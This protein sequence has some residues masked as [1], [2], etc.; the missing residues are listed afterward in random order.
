MIW[1]SVSSST[2]APRLGQVREPNADL[3]VAVLPLA[4]EQR[5]ALS[6]AGAADEVLDVGHPLE[7]VE[8]LECPPAREIGERPSSHE[9]HRRFRSGL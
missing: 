9:R 4:Q 6:R 1:Q 2:S 7:P 5:L 3:E 8:A